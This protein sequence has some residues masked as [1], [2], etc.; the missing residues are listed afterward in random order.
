LLTPFGIDMTAW[1]RTWRRAGAGLD[2]TAILTLAASATGR[3]IVAGGQDGGVYVGAAR[4]EGGGRWRR[5]GSLGPDHPVFSV[6]IAPRDGRTVLAGT[7]G[8]LYRGARTGHGWAWQRVARTGEAA[9]TAIAWAP[10]DARLAFASVFAAGPSVLVSHDAG[11]TW[12]PDSAGPPPALPTYALL[13]VAPPTPRVYLAAMG[14]GV[15]RWSAAGA[16]Q[17]ISAGL[18]ARHAMQLV[19]A[20]RGTGQVL[21]AGTMGAGVYARQGEERWRRLGRGLDGGAYTV[22]SLAL[23]SGPHPDLVVGTVRGL[24]R[25]VPSG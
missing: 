24:F 21:F 11:R 19:A 15:W 23:T 17:D 3:T 18:P 22:L 4:P 7:F 10:W 9:V 1:R 8:A 25:Y 14:G 6:S 20:R 13:A 2:G 5:I 12:R 16:W